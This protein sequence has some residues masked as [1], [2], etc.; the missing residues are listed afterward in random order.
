MMAAKRYDL[1]VGRHTLRDLSEAEVTELFR[2]GH[3]SPS[4]ACRLGG[5]TEW[6]EV[7]EYL[8]LLK[9]E[10]VG[11]EVRGSARGLSPPAGEVRALWMP[12]WKVGMICFAAGLLVA[13]AATTLPT[14][15]FSPEKPTHRR[16]S[17]VRAEP[18]EVSPETRGVARREQ[19][20]PRSSRSADAGQSGSTRQGVSAP[21][22]G[23]APSG[24]AAS[25]LGTSLPPIGPEEASIPLQ[26]WT[27][28]R[29]AFGS[30]RIKVREDGPG[31]I[32]V[33]FDH[34]D[35]PHRFEKRKGFE[36]YGT[37]TVEI[38]SLPGAKV[39]YV[40]RLTA[41]IGRCVLKVI[42]DA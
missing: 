29:S 20:T 18:L 32:S 22:Q 25:P 15:V 14:R 39:Y 16:V 19:G 36:A 34:S 6:Q 4:T 35:E 10:V 28:V 38:H 40:D 2:H 30:F 23:S 27:T 26:K 37:N 8:P 33:W 41:P 3:V 5:H 17:V 42:P 31:A 9:Y 7:N 1:R 11:R 21:A 24:S 12:Q 13:G